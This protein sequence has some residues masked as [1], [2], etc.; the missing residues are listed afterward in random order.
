[1]LRMN[2]RLAVF[3]IAIVAIQTVSKTIINQCRSA[4]VHQVLEAVPAIR[5]LRVSKVHVEI[6][7]SRDPKVR[8]VL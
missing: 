5:A 4:F 7:A 6:P 8:R 2:A 3:S 1:M